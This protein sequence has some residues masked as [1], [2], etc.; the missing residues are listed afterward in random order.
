MNTMN[1]N[2]HRKLL[3]SV[4]LGLA[5]WAAGAA[6]FARAAQPAITAR[7]ASQTVLALDRT[8]L[9]V[10]A[11]GAEPLGYQWRKDGLALQDDG[12]VRG[13]GS[14]TFSIAEVLPGDAGAYSV[15][16]TNA[17]GFV[18]SSNAVLTVAERL[19]IRRSGGS[20]G[21][22]GEGFHL[23][24]ATFRGWP[25]VVLEAS[26]DLRHWAPRLTNAAIDGLVE[27][28]DPAGGGGRQYYRVQLPNAITL[29]ILD[30]N[31]R[32]AQGTVADW[33]FSCL[34]EGMEQT[35]LF[36]AGGEAGIVFANAAKIGAQLAGVG[37]LVISHDHADHLA[38]LAPILRTNQHATVWL[39]YSASAA[40]KGIVQRAGA[41]LRQAKEAAEVCQNVHLTGELAGSAANEQALILETP[42]GLVVIV[43]CAHPGIVPMLE[44]AR[45]QRNREIFWVIGGFHLIDGDGYDLPRSTILSVIDQVRKLGVKKCSATHC[46][47][48]LAIRLFQE[49]FG[50]DYEPAGT[51]RIKVLAR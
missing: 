11:T 45:Q 37:H 1:R 27:F 12:R 33:G 42:E 8:V 36:D 47:G 4:G 2:W 13:T 44:R 7:P 51:G 5:F 31:Y 22:G 19:Q 39:P 43:G 46:T 30:D 50:N 14:N 41:P 17:E 20:L 25:A 15:L 18:I 35:I 26:D 49:A 21:L 48:A 38:A 24:A 34:I 9:K 6:G 3:A 32:Y 23:S 10:S 16:V 28:A 40:T 29:T